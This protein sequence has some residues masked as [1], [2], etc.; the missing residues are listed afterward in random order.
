MPGRGHMVVIHPNGD[1]AFLEYEVTWK[2]G[3]VDTP[4]ELVG[5][6]VQGTGKFT[7]IRG[8]WTERGLSTMAADTSEW[9]VEYSVRGR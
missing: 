7:G 5:H 9:E 2:P 6:F 1:R 3:T 8:R 4:F